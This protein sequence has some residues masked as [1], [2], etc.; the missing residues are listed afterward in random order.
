VTQVVAQPKGPDVLGHPSHHRVLAGSGVRHH[1]DVAVGLGEFGDDQGVQADRED[2]AGHEAL[3]LLEERGV[4]D[5]VAPEDQLVQGYQAG[6]G[7]GREFRDHS[8]RWAAVVQGCRAGNGRRGDR[9]S[10]SEQP[11]TNA[12]THPRLL[13]SPATDGDLGR[14]IRDR[15]EL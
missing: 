8:G 3:D 10:C 1:L 11:D 12:S 4:D 2:A 13:T 14:T 9:S 5:V 7:E 6:G 15:S